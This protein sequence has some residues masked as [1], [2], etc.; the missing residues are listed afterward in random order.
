MKVTV[1]QLKS[2]LIRTYGHVLPAIRVIKKEHDIDIS[3]NAVY[4]RMQKH[5]SIKEAVDGALENLKDIAEHELARNITQGNMT[6]IMFFLK[7]K[8]K[9]RGY[10][11]KVEQEHTG[12]VK[13]EHTETFD[14]SD[15]SDEDLDEY[16]ALLEKIESK[17]KKNE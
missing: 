14:F 11:E 13:I 6:A 7:I 5:P 8:A 4:K 17:K 1:E 15:W 2:A 12:E 9:D 3:R 16:I 10:V